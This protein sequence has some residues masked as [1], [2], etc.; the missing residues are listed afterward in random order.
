MKLSTFADY[1]GLEYSEDV[2]FSQVKIDSRRVVPGDLFVAFPGQKVDGHDYAL[3]AVQ[4]GAVAIL[5]QKPL[6]N[7]HVPVLVVPD[8]AQALTIAAKA[9]R[10]TWRMKVLALT[11]SN[12]KT[13]VKE[14]L[15]SIIPEPRF[16]SMGNFNN[17]LGVPINIL[18][19]HPTS[20][21]AIFELGANHRGDITHTASLVQ[22]DIALINN[23]GPAHLQGFGSIEGV[24]VAKGEIYQSLGT[25]GIAVVNDDDQY[26]HFW[27]AH[28][29]DKRVIRFSCEREKEV[30]ASGLLVD[31]A[32]CFQFEL[33]IVHQ[34]QKLHLKVPG[35]HQVHNA[36]AAASMAYAAG[37]EL[38]TIVAGLEKFTGVGGRLNIKIGFN[39][40][41]VI[42]DTY[43]ANLASVKAGLE[44]LSQR[45]GEKILVIGDLG[46]LGDYE[47]S[48]HA[49]I[50]KIAKQLGI[51]QLL[52]VGQKT[53]HCVEAFGIGASHFTT[54]EL[55]INYLKKVLNNQVSVLVKGSRSAR[56]EE[57]VQQLSN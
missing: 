38:S 12:G 32:G 56:M 54:R 4:Q 11:G 31:A 17:Q 40:S 51:N 57:I 16:C 30:W 19:V 5:A 41:T 34:S 18:N 55:L 52:A 7:L 14:M 15:G 49:E 42:D 21:Y 8:C 6:R 50:G 45:P 10:Q 26:A 27:D 43:N 46:E 1:L 22:P 23:I 25:N 47:Q 37:I 36:L 48:Q 20:K 35:K 13:S 39:Q 53:T 33:H 2:E 9:Y 29:V 28:L 24:A 44:Y 3:A